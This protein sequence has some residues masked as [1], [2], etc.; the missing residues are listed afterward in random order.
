MYR[1][2]RQ[3]R[4]I[5][6]SFDSFLDVVANVVGIIIRL[7]LIT[8]VGSKSYTGFVLPTPPV[9]APVAIVDENV[10][11]PEPPTVPTVLPLVSGSNSSVGLI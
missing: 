4:E 8:W 1:R 9:A 3:K 11:L 5:P 7:I 2:R 10:T 6:F